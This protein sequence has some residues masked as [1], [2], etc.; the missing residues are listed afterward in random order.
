MFGVWHFAPVLA[1]VIFVIAV[2][3]TQ[4]E[5]GDASTKDAVTH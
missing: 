2:R 1:L 4:I 5:Y 3:K